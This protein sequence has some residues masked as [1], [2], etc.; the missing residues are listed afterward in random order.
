MPLSR[1]HLLATGL[2]LPLAGVADAATAAAE[3]VV[4]E[5]QAGRL[6]GTRSGRVARFLG[7]P[8]GATTAG[9]RFRPPRPADRWRGIRDAL[10]YGD[11]SPQLRIGL[12]EASILK[13]FAIDRP[14]TEDCL[15]LN[16]WSA[17]ANDRGKRPVMVW[18]HGGGFVAG[19]GASV[20]YDGTRLAE[21]QDVVVV[22]V[23][24]RLGLFGHLWF[25]DAAGEAYAR[26]GNV[27]MLDLVLALE[28]VRGNAAAFGGDPGNVT[29]FGESGGG[30]K[31]SALMA[32]PAARGLFHKAVV[33]SGSLIKAHTPETAAPM[34][35]TIMAEFGLGPNDAMALSRLPLGAIE[36]KLPA[37]AAKVGW[38]MG[39]VIGPD[40]PQHP[41]DPAAP[42]ASI[43]VPLLVG[44]NKD[45]ATLIAGAVD[46]GA[47]ML[48]EAGLAKKLG[49]MSPTG[50]IASK[51]RRIYPFARPSD[52]YF[53]AASWMSVRRNATIQAERKA[54]Q[55][56][57]P[58][59][60][61]LLAWETPVEGGR[62][63]SPHA[64]DLP[65]VFDT[66]AVSPQLVGDGGQA[67]R[68][69]DAMSAAW[70]RFART[71]DPGWSRYDLAR[72]TTMVFDASSGVVDDP[73]RAERLLFAGPPINTL[74]PGR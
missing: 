52:L 28:W 72:R 9:R 56:G 26:S 3:P 70:A 6:R 47:F 71:G 50:D 49:M 44:A 18:L 68:V 37:I 45:E 22:T 33:Q 57:A 61:Y 16:V 58:A 7:I 41:F 67:Q 59:H 17:G 25:A 11:Q 63:K 40:L 60:S 48:D 43:D 74:A 66:V 21:R 35:A 53:T 65:L 64:L 8:Y 32:M 62:W 36:P 34:T 14:G 46:P 69:A 19:S 5:T 39:P 30:C 55:G 4:V 42:A 27:G 23:N 38:R 24:H 10:D 73:D 54:A 12:A 29:I 31:V 15:V 13:G 51:L 20:P 2:V 1:R